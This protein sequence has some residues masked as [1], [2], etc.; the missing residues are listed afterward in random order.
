[1]I[2]CIIVIIGVALGSKL[3][4]LFNGHCKA[5]KPAGSVNNIAATPDNLDED[6]R[7]SDL[8]FINKLF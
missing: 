7:L 5:I 4:A 2:V 8:T 6:L 1:M 3:K